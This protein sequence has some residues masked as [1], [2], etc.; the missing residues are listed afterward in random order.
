MSSS[1]TEQLSS[2]Y[3]KARPDCKHEMQPWP[4]GRD[5]G[6]EA[7]LKAAALREGTSL[8]VVASFQGL[9][10]QFYCEQGRQLP[11][12][13]GHLPDPY[14]VLVSEVMLQQTQVDRVIPRFTAFIERFPDAQALADASL[15]ELLTAWQGLGYNRRAL[16]LQRAARMIV[17]L[18]GGRLPDDPVLLQQLP[19]IG[20]YTAGAVAAFAF[21]RPQVFLETNVRAVLLHLFFADQEGIT[22][23]QL[24]PVVEAVLDRAEPRT[25]YNALMDYGSDLK[26]RFPNPSRRSRH[27]T[28]QSRFEGS[29]RQLRGAVLRFLLAAGGATLATLRKQ[30]DTEEE[31]LVRILEGMLEDGFLS[32]QGRKF[33]IPST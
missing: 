12:R 8:T 4:A 3:P 5:T 16:N 7:E 1:H 19:G 26:R 17:D 33:T 32:R 6:P 31:R 18:W 2:A 15:T 30:L 10:Y 20:P 27:H 23:K 28:R 9:V 25:W 14:R 11:W 13:G 21:N 24:L 22:D 29:D